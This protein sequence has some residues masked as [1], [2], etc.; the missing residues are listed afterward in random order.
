MPQKKQSKK[1]T[2]KPLVKKALKKQSRKR[3]VKKQSSLVEVAHPESSQ[4]RKKL[5]AKKQVSNL[6]NS[7]KKPPSPKSVAPSPSWTLDKGVSQSLLNRFLGCR[8]RFR[9]YAVEGMREKGSRDQMDFGTYFHDLLENYAKHNDYSAIDII[10]ITQPAVNKRC[11]NLSQELRHVCEVIFNRYVWY[12]SDCDYKY[13]DQEAVFAVEYKVPGYRS[14]TLRGR[15]DEV[16]HR[17]DGT[18]W[19]QENKTK[20]RINSEQLVACIPNNLQT[21]LYAVAAQ[22]HYGKRVS[23]IVY[24]VIRK[25][26]NK[27]SSRKMTPEELAVYL[28]EN[29]KSKAKTRP[30]TLNE[31]LERLDNLIEEDPKHFFMRWEFKLSPNHLDKWK[32]YTLDPV[33]ISLIQWWESVKH[34]PF[35]PWEDR[36]AKGKVKFC[37]QEKQAGPKGKKHLVVSPLVDEEGNKIPLPNPHHWQRPFGVYD[38]LT[39]S[40]GDFYDYLVLGRDNTITR[41]NTPFQ[42]LQ[43][44]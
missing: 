41:G 33:L 19:I 5:L 11:P 12:F 39:L 9:L 40:N 25:P 37:Q 1:L 7:P 42:E 43:E 6:R 16:I 15:L 36:D 38:A 4:E 23:G 3:S 32:K 10:K 24:N 20:E 30:E 8:E 29:P 22:E 27:P 31:F 14:I 21:M 26:K 2:K 17:P 28:Q 13:M 35:S 34:D 18:I 44:E